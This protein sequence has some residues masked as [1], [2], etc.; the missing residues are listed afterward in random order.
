M[1][2][3]PSSFPLIGTTG[4]KSDIVKYSDT[5]SADHSHCPISIQT[6]PYVIESDIYATIVQSRNCKLFQRPNSHFTLG[7]LSL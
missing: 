1:I 6:Y 7:S 4:L 5:P 3:H 2:I